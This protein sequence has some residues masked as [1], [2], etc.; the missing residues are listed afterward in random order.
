MLYVG[1][2]GVLSLLLIAALWAA[3][4][5]ATHT[6]AEKGVLDVD[7]SIVSSDNAIPEA[8]RTITVTLADKNL[9]TPLFVG[10]GPD[11]EAPDITGINT[12]GAGEGIT[13]DSAGNPFPPAF[14][15]VVLITLAG[16]PVG[17]GGATP[18]G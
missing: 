12:G 3:S 9:N 16:N 5:G 15:G 10:N 17:P 7:P 1:V 18:I 2:L 13:V 14:P 4:V 11:G 8:D 6:D